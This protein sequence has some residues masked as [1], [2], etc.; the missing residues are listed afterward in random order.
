MCSDSLLNL[1][2]RVADDN[3]LLLCKTFVFLFRPWVSP[4]LV[5]QPQISLMQW[6]SE[7]GALEMAIEGMIKVGPLIIPSNELVFSL[8][9]KS[10]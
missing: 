5:D 8:L 7:V 10:C 1:L 4:K 9:L 3:F 6:K 2:K